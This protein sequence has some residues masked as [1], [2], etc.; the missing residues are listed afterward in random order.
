MAARLSIAGQEYELQDAI[1]ELSA[2]VES[3]HA[4]AR[5]AQSVSSPRAI[6][7]NATIR[8]L[9]DALPNLP[10]RPSFELVGSIAC[11]D[12]EK[13]EA[14]SKFFE[15]LENVSELCN[16]AEA[17]R[18]RIAKMKLTGPALQFYRGEIELSLANYSD[19]K[20]RITERFSDKAPV[21][22]YF[23]QLSV[24]QQRHGETIEAFADRV[25]NLNEK[26]IRVTTNPEVNAAL[27]LEA[28]RRATDAF[29]RG[30]VG[31][32]GEQTKLK[33]PNTLR[34]AITTAV[35]IEHLGLSV[36]PQQSRQPSN[37]RRVFHS[38]I[39]CYNC[40]NK[41]HLSR[42]C[43]ERPRENPQ[44]HPKSVT[45]WRCQRPGH[46]SRDCRV[47]LYLPKRDGRSGN[48]G[49]AEGASGVAATQPRV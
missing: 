37:E 20:A 5:E 9:A 38:E 34:E 28:D 43:P 24:A 35:A 17:D 31:K 47:K 2:R 44:R 10:L 27:R 30:L 3:A 48:S 40:H 46:I 19:F 33:F 45:C 32:V 18:L 23:Q 26:T 12:G 8:D 16:W 11:F 39:V 4:L 29:V 41:G 49:N 13:P 6:D 7:M 21:H 22:L 25:R 15:E 42:A 36:N 14:I 1:N